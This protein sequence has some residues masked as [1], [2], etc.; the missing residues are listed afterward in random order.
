M[1]AQFAQFVRDVREHELVDPDGDLR[2]G[3]CAVVIASPDG[4][5]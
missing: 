3:C 1:F 5:A 2:S 4:E